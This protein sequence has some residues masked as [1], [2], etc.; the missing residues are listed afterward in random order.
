MGSTKICLPTPEA[1]EREETTEIPD[2]TWAVAV[3]DPA[4]LRALHKLPVLRKTRVSLVLAA[5]RALPVKQLRE[6]RAALQE[7][8]AEGKRERTDFV[9]VVW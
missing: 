1:S 8:R 4:C 2:L 7:R 6:R 3:Q 9:F 5:F